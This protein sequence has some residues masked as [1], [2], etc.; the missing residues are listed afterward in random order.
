MLTLILLE[1]LL[2]YYPYIVRHILYFV[3]LIILCISMHSC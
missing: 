3:L 2:I 1:L